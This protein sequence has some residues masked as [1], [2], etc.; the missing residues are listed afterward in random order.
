[1]DFAGFLLKLI[2]HPLGAFAVGVS[3]MYIV[4]LIMDRA[5]RKRMAR[6]EHDRSPEGKDERIAELSGQVE[7]RN[8]R[9]TDLEGQVK[10]L[11]RDQKE[12][13]QSSQRLEKAQDKEIQVVD[14]R[15][16]AIKA[17]LDQV[18][19]ECA[20]LTEQLASVTSERDELQTRVGNL[21]TELDS[22]FGE[23]QE[24]SQDLD[25]Q[26]KALEDKNASLQTELD[27]SPQE[28]D[29]HQL[30]DER[31]QLEGR[32]EVYRQLL[33]DLETQLT[34]MRKQATQADP[35]DKLEVVALAEENEELNQQL[36]LY[37][38][39]CSE[40]EG[41][42]GDYRR[43]D[44]MTDESAE[45]QDLVATNLTNENVELS[46]RLDEYMRMIER[47]KQEHEEISNL[48][49]D[50]EEL[51]SEFEDRV[52]KEAAALQETVSRLKE[53]LAAAEGEKESLIPQIE[54]IEE[55]QEELTQKE[56]ESGKLEKEFESVRR[57]AIILNQEHE[58]ELA[59]L[60]QELE[61]A[62]GSLDILRSENK[63]LQDEILNLNAQP[64]EE[65]KLFDEINDVGEELSR[66]LDEIDPAESRKITDYTET[67]ILSDDDL[68]ADM[69]EPA[70]PKVS[71]T[72]TMGSFNV[73]LPKM[74]SAKRRA[75]A[76]PLIMELAGLTQKAAEKLAGRIVIP[77]AK[78]IDREKADEL[79]VRFKEIGI[80]ARVKRQQ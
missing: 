47:M 73:F 8:G 50:H 64:A 13:Q 76:V 71:D 56:K 37:K 57:D 72:G 6:E 63:V 26:I 43:N 38:K 15:M 49:R 54:R 20:T 1:M 48:R 60:R 80:L 65:V 51:K 30:E 29:V 66:R 24:S 69:T 18:S 7:E 19:A 67:P 61:D 16:E 74:T 21:A 59:R 9:I 22:R 36:G 3:I 79:K 42:V 4:I 77:I 45:Y 58:T 12:F 33:G 41:Q 27:A 78:G 14:G 23:N 32:L 34:Q 62:A 40:L 53:Q 2:K 11:E 52:A 17:E 31:D 25:K 75:D 70:V 10:T 28:E 35:D 68:I 39:L 55:L 5:H 46:K 44:T